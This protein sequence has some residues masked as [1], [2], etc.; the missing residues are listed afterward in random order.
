MMFQVEAAKGLL[1]GSKRLFRISLDKLI[2]NWTGLTRGP[3]KLIRTENLTLGLKEKLIQAADP[4]ILLRRGFALVFSSEGKWVQ[5]AE[6]LA[7]DQGIEMRFLDGVAKA[8]I[9]KKEIKPWEQS[10]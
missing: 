5:R 2:L 4:A 1:S 6:D 10:Q 7:V 3:S 9:E 8:R